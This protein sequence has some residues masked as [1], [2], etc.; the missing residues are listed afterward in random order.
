MPRGLAGP[1]PFPQ[2]P[3]SAM[4]QQRGVLLTR[5][6]DDA[7]RIA[8]LIEAR[9]FVPVYAPF[10]RVHTR[11]AALPRGVQ[12]LLVTSARA[13]DGVSPWPVPVLA[14]G[15]A[16]AARARQVGFMN[17]T[18]ARG[19]AAAL[20]DLAACSLDPGAGKLLLL[21]GAGQG[22]AIAAALRMSGFP[23]LRRVTYAAVP[24]RRFPAA[25]GV[26]L[27]EDRLHAAI[28]LSGETAAAFAR[29]L[30]PLL[31][32]HLPGVL[33]LAIG[34]SAADAL[35]P[36]PWR[37]IRLAATPTLDDVLALL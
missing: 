14:V 37:D 21:S 6:I 35:K 26:A 34:K 20:A 32:A 8:P 4:T 31:T 25:A 1:A 36:L 11:A 19:D 22:G 15:D 9:R 29:L 28:F 10:L 30:P 27:R 5:P 12:A 16:T 17:V 7:R 13:L 23:V 3:A 24:V 18:S 33:A 2:R